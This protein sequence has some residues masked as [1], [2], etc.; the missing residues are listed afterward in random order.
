MRQQNTWA[1]L[2]LLVEVIGGNTCIPNTSDGYF[3]LIYGLHQNLKIGDRMFD[4]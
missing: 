2:R 4:D 1:K 3:F